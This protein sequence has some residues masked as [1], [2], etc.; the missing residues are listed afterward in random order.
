MSHDSAVREYLLPAPDTFWEWRDDGEVITWKDGTTI[1][2]RDELRTVLSWLAPHGLP[3]LNSIALLL[4]AT[5]DNWNAGNSRQ[6]LLA[7][8]R[9]VT[10]ENGILYSAMEGLGRVNDLEPLLRAPVRAK[11]VL[12]E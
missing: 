11:S 7:G 8:M 10:L 3:P 9:H 2:F 1:A 12:A 6:Y 5:H 4:A